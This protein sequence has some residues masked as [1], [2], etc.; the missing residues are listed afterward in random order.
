[1]YE[2]SKEIS[3]LERTTNISE[4]NPQSSSS[5]VDN[6]TS[7]QSQKESKQQE[8]NTIIQNPKHLRQ[9]SLDLFGTNEQGAYL[10]SLIMVDRTLQCFLQIVSNQQ[11]DNTAQLQKKAKHTLL[12]LKKA[13]IHIFSN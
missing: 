8:F 13:Y 11:D 2:D 10:I 9:D 3:S 5:D 1:M 12:L 6:N 4:E 7:H